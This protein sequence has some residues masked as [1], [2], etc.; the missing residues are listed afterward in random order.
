MPTATRQMTKMNNTKS[1]ISAF[2]DLIAIAFRR[3]AIRKVVFSR[4]INT[5]P[6]KASA[7]LC[8]HR[9]QRILAVEYSLEGD[10]VSQKN[11][12]E[13]EL[14]DYLTAEISR[15]RQINLI[16]ECGDA[17]YK[18]NKSGAPVLLGADKLKRRLEGNSSAFSALQSLDRKKSY[19]L[20]GSEEFLIRLG[21]SDK[22][23]RVHDKRQGKFRQINRFLEYLSECYGRLRPDGELFVLDLCCGKSYL[24]FA[25]Y[26]YLTEIKKRQVRML[27]IDL[28]RDV[29]DY[30]Q[31][32]ARELGFFGMQF[33]VDDIANAPSDTPPDMV[34]SLHA[35]DVATDV[36]LYHAARLRAKVILSTPCCHREL[37]E[38]IDQ[39]TLCFVTKYPKLKGKLCEAITDALRLEY[40]D[41]HGYEVSATELTDP[42]D[43]PKNTLLRAYLA[44][45]FSESK[46]ADYQRLLDFVLGKNRDKYLP[47]EN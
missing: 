3:E 10:T 8:A 20:S 6:K 22:G 23:G 26:Y 46:Y 38:H 35:C 45:D 30:C 25:V 21:I 40:L 2:A 36:V 24:S 39:S 17:E 32:S 41:A 42:D 33:I 16:T 1:E 28:K 29:I 43:T 4:P 12:R 37:S 44:G 15:Y 18:L 47:F 27:G 9:G 13:G 31:K 34:I 14:C 7:R 19:I 5:A 11:V